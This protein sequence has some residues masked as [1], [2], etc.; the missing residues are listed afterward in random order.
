M[1]STSTTAAAAAA[2]ANKFSLRVASS[3]VFNVFSAAGALGPPSR[4]AA[5]PSSALAPR[6]PPASGAASATAPAPA[7]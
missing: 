7:V 5:E 4:R 3:A 6:V 2:A 1:T